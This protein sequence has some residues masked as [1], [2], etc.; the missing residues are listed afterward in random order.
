[1]KLKSGSSKLKSNGSAIVNI[2]LLIISIKIYY[3][4][5]LNYLLK[6]HIFKISV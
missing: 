6:C 5:E 3:L 4:M 1:M 2:S